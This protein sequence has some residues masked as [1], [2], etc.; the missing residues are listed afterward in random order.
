MF[1][2]TYPT[3]NLLVLLQILCVIMWLAILFE[4]VNV[5]LAAL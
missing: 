3:I 5:I 1:S 4:D 2:E